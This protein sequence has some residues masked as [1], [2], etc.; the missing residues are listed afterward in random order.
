MLRILF[1]LVLFKPL[2]SFADV[3]CSTQDFLNKVCLSDEPQELTG[4]EITKLK[5]QSIETV[6]VMATQLRDAFERAPEWMKKKLCGL[7]G[8]GVYP[9]LPGSRTLSWSYFRPNYVGISRGF[10]ESGY[11]FSKHQETMRRQSLSK[12][13]LAEVDFPKSF[14]FQHTGADHGLGVLYLLTHEVGHLIYNPL[15][16]AGDPDLFNS[17]IV[18]GGH[19]NCNPFKEHHWGFI[20]W[21]TAAGPIVPGINYGTPRPHNQNLINFVLPANKTTVDLKAMDDFYREYLASGFVTPFSLYSPE[22]DFCETLAATVVARE[23]ESWRF[24]FLDGTSF[25]LRAKVL[26]PQNPELRRKIDFIQLHITK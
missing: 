2:I 10:L 15:R 23:L 21:I 4:E 12:K 19:R 5:C 17:C 20:S 22:E 13:S 1:V 25:D 6:P 24:Q 16:K 11:S 8:L 9:T 26:S 3:P 18:F 7:N 14:G